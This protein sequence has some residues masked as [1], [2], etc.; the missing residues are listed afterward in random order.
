M[1][2]LIIS[3]AVS[4][5]KQENDLIKTDLKKLFMCLLVDSRH[6]SEV[7]VEHKVILNS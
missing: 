5:C 4:I 1:K 2:L 7:E 3:I 6:A